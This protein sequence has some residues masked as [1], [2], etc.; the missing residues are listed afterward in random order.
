MQT[1]G[2]FDKKRIFVNGLSSL[3]Q[4]VIT[5]LTYFFLYKYLY[6]Y[7]G[8][9]QLGLWSLILATTSVVSIGSLGVSGS[10]V[11]FVAAY[12]AKKDY[13]KV[14]EVVYTGV[15]I[16]TVFIAVFSVIIY[17]LISY[18]LKSLVSQQDIETARALLP[19]ALVSLI[20][21]TIGL[22]FLSAVDGLQ[23]IYL[24]NILLIVF[25]VVFLIFVFI[26]VPYFKIVG[27]AYAQ[28][29]QSVGTLLGG[30]V[31]V[32]R[33]IKGFSIFRWTFSKSVFRELFAYGM[34]VQA[35]SVAS[36]LFDPITKFFLTKFGGL[37]I[38]GIYEM[39]N[40]LVL[41]LRN[42]IITT[43]Q[44][45]VPAI[46]GLVEVGTAN[47]KKTY[48][49]MFEVISFSSIILT[50]YILAF[51]KFIS[52]IWIGKI[53]PDFVIAI[54][55]VSI[56]WLFNLFSGPAFLINLATGRL[57]WNLVS[58]LAIGVFNCIFCYLFGVFFNKYYIILGASLSLTLSALLLIYFFNRHY[59]ITFAELL[60]KY[61]IRLIITS[62]IVIIANNYLFSRAVN[63]LPVYP[64][65]GV[66]FILISLLFYL[67]LRTHPLKLKILGMAKIYVSPPAV[68]N[69][70]PMPEKENVF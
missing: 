17:F 37:S 65:F 10:A 60:S 7:L 33:K 56:G 40:K 62:V 69:E 39:A 51:S 9:A 2:G 38:V 48:K 64:F 53:Q 24:K 30:V 47:I 42:L 15:L 14:N 55:L 61:L 57:R 22:I 52:I 45:L 27:V 11:K 5:I 34:K 8:A 58:Q 49:G 70:K 67:L 3:V 28:T 41:Q 21:N 19:Y 23:L 1:E 36:M 26:L 20:A 4:V 44:V 25:S 12:T 54:S 6:K 16:T 50:T 46:A 68:V 66:G 59:K 18:L 32:S 13:K 43:S 63:I 31:L 35:M 29:I